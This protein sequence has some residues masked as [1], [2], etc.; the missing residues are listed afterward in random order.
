ML[1]AGYL[2]SFIYACTMGGQ[3]QPPEKWASRPDV[4]QLLAYMLAMPA[5]DHNVEVA[6]VLNGGALCTAQ[7]ISLF[8]MSSRLNFSRQQ[9]KA[10][11][12]KN[13][14][15]AYHTWLYHFLGG[16]SANEAD[17][18]SLFGSAKRDALECQASPR[19]AA[20]RGRVRPRL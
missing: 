5:A 17:A 15:V 10:S 6:A 13:K 2:S 18:A 7:A 1:V 4:E 8:R 14:G 20:R 16:S 19:R 11:V 3:E 9:W 12:T